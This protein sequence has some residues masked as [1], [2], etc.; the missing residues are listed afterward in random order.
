MKLK[1]YLNEKISLTGEKDKDK[2]LK[3]LEGW[4]S[5]LRKMTKIYKSVE[6][7]NTPKAVKKFKEGMKL[8]GTFR[9]NWERWYTQFIKKKFVPGEDNTESIYSKEARVKGW[10]A[11]MAINNIFPDDYND[12]KFTPRPDLLDYPRYDKGDTRKN[13]I[14]RYQKAFKHAFKAIEE[15]IK[16][17]FELVTPDSR[18]QINVA[19]INLLITQDKDTS[20]WAKKKLKLFID[21]LPKAV[22]AIKAAGFKDSLKGLTVK[23]RLTDRPGHGGDKGGEYISYEDTLA[24]YTWGMADKQKALHTLVHEIGHRFYRRSLPKKA[25]DAWSSAIW[26]K[27][28]HVEKHHVEA[29]FRKYIEG[30]F[31]PKWD[32]PNE[33]TDIKKPERNKLTDLVKKNENDPNTKA[34]YQYLVQTISWSTSLK[35]LLSYEGERIHIEFITDYARK[36]TE[37]AFCEAFAL[38][39]GA[40]GKLGEWTRDF[41]KEVVRSGGANIKEEK[42]MNLIDKY[43]GEGKVRGRKPSFGSHDGNNYAVQI[44]GLDSNEFYKQPFGRQ[45]GDLRKVQEW[46]K[47]AKSTHIGAKGKGTMPS[48]KKWVKEMNLSE[49]Y[50]MWKKDSSSYKD[51]SVEI[52]YVK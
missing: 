41:F 46:K 13:K 20:D 14:I 6:A 15:L 34:V 25:Q 2:W 44:N 18:D 39:V 19:G 30:K 10:Q 28:I 16:Y 51:D 32:D 47:T 37:E 52:F 29:F 42:K 33:F 1:R 48:V 3:E 26:K 27:F 49:F 12:G 17:Q 50:A 38:W 43:L 31:P 22:K 7:E 23:L 24:L 35:E 36:N 5:D 45:L 11:E 8:F 21:T 4:K 9:E 40:R